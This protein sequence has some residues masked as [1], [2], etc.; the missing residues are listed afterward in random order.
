[1]NTFERPLWMAAGLLMFLS[2]GFTEM[3]GSDMWWHLA[4]GREL[5]QTGTPWMVDDWS[6][7]HH[8]EDWLN[9]EWLADIVYYSWVSLLGVP[10]IVYWKWLV[11]LATFA[12]LQYGLARETKSQ[13]AGFLCSAVAVAIAAP[14]I[15]VRPHLYTL[16]N[17]AILL[18]MLLGRRFPTWALALFFVLWVNMHGGFFFGLMALGILLFPWREMS[19]ANI[20]RAFLIGL[21]C[22]AAC[23][24]NPSGFGVFLYPLKYAFDQSSPFRQLAEWQSP[25]S[26]GGIRSPLFFYFMWA[27]VAAVLYAIPAI[28]KR[29]SIPWEG[30]MLTALTLAM[31]L[32]SRR[33]IPIYAISLAVM[34]APLVAL[35]FSS[36]RFSKLRIGLA[37]LGVIIALLRLQPY[38]LS[39]GPSFHYLVAEYSYPIDMLD[40]IEANQIS[41]KVYAL[42]NWGGYIHWRTDG[43]LKVFIDGRAD[44]LYDAD[45]YN[46][47]VAVLRGGPDWIGDIERSGAKYIIWP[48]QRNNGVQ[49]LTEL[50]ASGRWQPVYRDAAGFMLA[51]ADI[52]L[53][54]DY[55]S[56][57]PGPYQTLGY[58]HG[59]AASGQAGPAIRYFEEVRKVLPYQQ[60]ACTSLARIYRAT[61]QPAQAETVLGECRQEFPSRYLR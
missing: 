52:D 56:G 45:T 54:D 32:T 21:A 40:F 3:M 26:P 4:A 51:R 15:D 8:G 2:F 13:L 34:L 43:R 49:K 30:I 14:F 20:Q 25:F 39:S 1:M 53:P 24:L 17:F 44:T 28:R 55:A 50:V 60:Q 7:T 33:F 41:G 6:F 9:H 31:A 19:V 57:E 10:S 12:T 46:A 16:L 11:V 35:C 23:L 38:P 27:P 58:A 22:A 42:Y 61:Q 47:Y 18:A 48:N 59:L 37:T 5:F 36:T 29:T